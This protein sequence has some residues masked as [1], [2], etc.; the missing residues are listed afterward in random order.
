MSKPA[1]AQ[2]TISAQFLFFFLGFSDRHY[3]NVISL[4]YLMSIDFQYS[5]LTWQDQ[6]FITQRQWFDLLSR[7]LLSRVL[8]AH[9]IVPI[10]IAGNTEICIFQCNAGKGNHNKLWCARKATSQVRRTSYHREYLDSDFPLSMSPFTHDW[11]C[12]EWQATFLWQR[13]LNHPLDR[14]KEPVNVLFIDLLIY[15]VL[16][17]LWILNLIK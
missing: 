12:I 7:D 14:A 2:I 16:S 13:D 3:F 1:C 9:I 15:L 17:K 5:F 11:W 4:F 10:V 6:I 8:T